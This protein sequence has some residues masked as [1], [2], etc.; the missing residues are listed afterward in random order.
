MRKGKKVWKVVW[1]EYYWG[2]KILVSKL[3]QNISNGNIECAGKSKIC[4]LSDDNP[5]GAWCFYFTVLI[6]T[7]VYNSLSWVGT[8]QC[9]TI[10]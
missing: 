3:P 6:L 10:P 5:F 9:M 1:I 7:C 8:M 2:R 4:I